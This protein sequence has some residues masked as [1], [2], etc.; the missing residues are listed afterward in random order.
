[1]ARGYPADDAAPLRRDAR[2]PGLDVLDIPRV[3]ELAHEHG[4]PLLVD[5]TFT[6]P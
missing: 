2:Q 1:M 6:T 4:L 5:S 3:A